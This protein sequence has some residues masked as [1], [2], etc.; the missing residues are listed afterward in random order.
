MRKI[1][2]LIIKAEKVKRGGLQLYSA[3]I[4]PEVID[5]HQT[6]KQTITADFYN[7]R[8]AGATD[9]KAER[10]SYTA[11][12]IEDAITLLDNLGRQYGTPA[13]GVKVIIDD[14]ID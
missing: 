1:D 6:G 11:D 13:D 7:A 10:K 12:S 14:F 9:H 2:K 8:P 4:A 3:L 5:G